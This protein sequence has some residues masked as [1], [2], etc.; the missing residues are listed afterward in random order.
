MFRLF[1][2]CNFGAECGKQGCLN[3]KKLITQFKKKADDYGIKLG[4]TQEIML[5]TMLELGTLR[6]IDLPAKIQNGGGLRAE[7]AY[8][9]L[10]ELRQIC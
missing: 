10:D 7:C 6:G 4:M 5:Q 1:S 2:D 8:L 9:T 3:A